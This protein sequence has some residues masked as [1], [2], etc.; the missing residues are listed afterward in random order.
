MENVNIHDPTVLVPELAEALGDNSLFSGRVT[1]AHDTRDTPFFPTEG[2]YVELGYEQVGVPDGIFGALTDQAVRQFQEDSGLVIDG[3][4]GPVTWE[5][6]FG[7][8]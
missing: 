8:E 5:L 4:V 2:H 1:L 3:V 6:L 7:E